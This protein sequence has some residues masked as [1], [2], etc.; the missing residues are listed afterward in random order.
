M[1][2]YKILFLWNSSFILAYAPKYQVT[3][4]NNIYFYIYFFQY[5]QYVFEGYLSFYQYSS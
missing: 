4:C 2:G 1:F 5:T 3:H